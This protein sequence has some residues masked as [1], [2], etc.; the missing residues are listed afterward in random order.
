M[1]AGS[2]WSPRFAVFGDMGDENGRSIPL[3]KKDV[4]AGLYDTILHVG[5][6]AYDMHDNEGRVAD[7]FMRQVEPI[8]ANVAYQTCVGNHEYKQ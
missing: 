2:D 5:D 8:A 1:K 3:L 6:I 4:A 7:S